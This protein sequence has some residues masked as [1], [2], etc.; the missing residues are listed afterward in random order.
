ML[1]GLGVGAAG[2]VAPRTFIVNAAQSHATIEVG[3]AGLF[4]F[5]AGHTHEVDA[6]LLSGVIHFDPANPAG[7]DLHLDFDAAALRVTGKGDP[8]A[9]VP[10][11]QAAMVG[12]Q[13]L[14]VAKYPKIAFDSTAVKLESGGGATLNLTVTGTMRLH[15]VSRPVTAQVSATLDGEVLIATGQ[16]TLKQTDYGIKPVSV[17]GVVKVKDALNISFRIV[18]RESAGSD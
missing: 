9:D 18:A 2:S 14:D 8:P 12:E 7:S 4:S 5:M 1:L 13:V 11:V 3:K 6:P 16:F 10:K 17:A 15:G